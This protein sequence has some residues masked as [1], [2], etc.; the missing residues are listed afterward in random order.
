MKAIE[1]LSPEDR[2]A[3]A[4]AL[5]QID[6]FATAEQGDKADSA[7]QPEQL[8]PV[9]TSNDYDD[10]SDKPDLGGMANRDPSEFAT[11]AQGAK[12]DT[13]VQPGALGSAA[14]H[15]ATDFATA[16]QGAKADT[17]VQP[18][19]LG[20]AASRPVADFATAAQGAKADTAVQ[21]GEL[22][23]AASRPVAD[24]ATAAQG[25]AADSALQP[26]APV[27]QLTET[28]AAKIFQAGERR[29]IEP[30]EASLAQMLA[31]GDIGELLLA[32]MD[33]AHNFGA[34]LGPD[35]SWHARHLR[36]IDSLSAR[37]IGRPQ[38]GPRIDIGEYDFP[39]AITDPAGNVFAGYQ[40]GKWFGPGSVSERTRPGLFS[41]TFFNGSCV[42][43]GEHN[44]DFAITDDQ[45][46]VLLGWLDGKYY[47]PG[48]TDIA[49]SLDAQDAANKAHGQSVYMRRVT[50]VQRPTAPFNVLAL[51]GQSL[52]QGDETWPALSRTPRLGNLMLG[53]NV[54][55]STDTGVFT[56]FAPTGLR[57]L[58]AMTVNGSTSYPDETTVQA[59][60]SARGEPPNIGWANGAKALLNDYLLAENDARALVT[61]NAAR[62]GAT[63]GELEKGH[64]EGTV[65]LYGKY[66]GAL[67]QIDTAV[68]A[69]SWV[70]AGVTYMQGE[71]DYFQASGHNSQNMT[72]ASYRAKLTTMAFNMQ[73]DA[74]A[75]TGQ[76]R[77]PAFL[78]Y[79]TGAGYTR[80][81][82]GN[83]SPGLHVGM[84]Q[85]DFALT[86]DTAW[87]VGPVYPYTD[88][89]GHFDSNGSRWFGHQIAKVFQQV[90]VEGRDWEPLRPLRIWRGEP[91]TIYVA[92]HVP[93]PP[94]IFDA[95]QI[96]AGAEWSQDNRGFRV[97]DAVGGVTVLSAEIVRDTII[98]L[99]L[100]RPVIGEALLWFASQAQ[101]GNGMV[102]DSDP[103]LASDNY[104]YEPERGMISTANI[105]D[106]VNKPYPLQNW[107]V[108]FC[109]PVEN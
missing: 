39:I 86:S 107:S 67:D 65:E 76:A 48:G 3:M 109:L 70:V 96:A 45:D 41:T 68:G 34:G 99:N 4:V 87:M 50:S 77:P 90:V 105:P 78:I 43:I 8:A 16:A 102:R 44:Y 37:S 79:Q 12:A 101:G 85:L 1:A 75:V 95:P 104:V 72:Y 58:A 42:E 31:G 49:A 25:V 22:G 82:D 28:A 98:K 89:G 106:L 21:P 26:G 61:I 47:G 30:L 62:S 38:G 32:F 63:I 92:Y 23:S 64:T 18:G 69:D 53:G 55:S 54:M 88:K 46:N 29:N 91:A 81:V 40:G 80:D 83:G 93:H 56:Q 10:L 84:A 19:E 59:S 15:P 27:D 5:S 20:S 73:S 108:A 97:T 94:L 33:A 17:A 14:G 57:P 13:A 66:L 51:Y 35:G 52:A 71:H 9:A 11:A 7:V 100:S 103:A 60:G 74:I 2:A 24:F 36:A 6:A